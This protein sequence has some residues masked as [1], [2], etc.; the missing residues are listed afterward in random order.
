[1]AASFALD[2][3]DLARIR[4]RAARGTH[5]D[6]GVNARHHQN[7]RATRGEGVLAVPAVLLRATI[8]AFGIVRF[9]RPRR[10]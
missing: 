5:H 3:F 8:F 9:R 7:P 6:C 1:M 4:M 2:H 10:R